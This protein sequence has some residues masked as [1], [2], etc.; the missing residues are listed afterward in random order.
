MTGEAPAVGHVRGAIMFV[1]GFAL[2]WLSQ[3]VITPHIAAWLEPSF[4]PSTG[5]GLFLRHLL[6]FSLA[7]AA[8]SLAAWFAFAHA[9]WLAPPRPWLGFGP[10]AIRLGVIAGVAL[11]AFVLIVGVAL[12]ERIHFHPDAWKMAG[13]VFSNYYEEL[14]YRGLL[15]QAAWAATGSRVGA[16]VLSSLVFGWSHMH[17]SHATEM[18]I[19]A[20]IAG[21]V[22]GALAIRTRSLGGAWVAHQV[23]DMIL[24]SL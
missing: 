23:S 24:D 13:N 15:M 1:V 20:T 18:A 21:C 9:G 19:G 7:T 5:S 17:G 3:R 12:G 8:I 11:S 14:S 16:V 2:L 4:G 10:G 22:F 6:T